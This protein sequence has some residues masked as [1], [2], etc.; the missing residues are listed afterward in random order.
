MS[1]Q[2]QTYYDT[3]LVNNLFRSVLTFRDRLKKVSNNIMLALTEFAQLYYLTKTCKIA[4]RLILM[5][6]IIIK[7]KTEYFRQIFCD[8]GEE[9]IIHDRNGKELITK[10][11]INVTR[12][13]IPYCN[14]SL[15]TR[16]HV[17]N[18]HT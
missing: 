18:L 8:F 5:Y 16:P 11:V 4:S 12:V 10:N 17:F 14:G 2:G 13:R 9:H 7:S 6:T 15:A 3:Y 1:S